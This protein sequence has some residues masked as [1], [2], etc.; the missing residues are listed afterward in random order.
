M[1]CLIGVRKHS[2]FATATTPVEFVLV[3]ANCAVALECRFVVSYAPSRLR[4]ARVCSCAWPLTLSLVE[5][6]LLRATRSAMFETVLHTPQKCTCA[7]RAWNDNI[8]IQKHTKFRKRVKTSKRGYTQLPSA[9]GIYDS[10]RM[11]KKYTRY[12]IIDFTMEKF[13]RILISMK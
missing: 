5:I 4:S 2:R 7:F 11:Y 10:G 12:H 9:P 6:P 8:D 1:S 13:A 3:H